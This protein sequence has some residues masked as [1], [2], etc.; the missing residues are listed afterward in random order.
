MKTAMEKRVYNCARKRQWRRG[1]C[2]P[3]YT[4]ARVQAREGSL[5]YSHNFTH[6]DRILTYVG[7]KPEA[8]RVL[9]F[10]SAFSFFPPSRSLPVS[11]ARE[12]RLN[13]RPH[14]QRTPSSPALIPAAACRHPCW[15]TVFHIQNAPFP[16][17]SYPRLLSHLPR[18]SATPERA[19]CGVSPGRNIKHGS[20]VCNRIRYTG[21]YTRARRCP[22]LI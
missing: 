13:E 22:A 16:A 18:A 2:E 6:T 5:E 14:N 8:S 1:T 12:S 15:E 19:F 3:I 11:L 10:Y 21:W 20:Y 7:R 17:V 4:C 9:H